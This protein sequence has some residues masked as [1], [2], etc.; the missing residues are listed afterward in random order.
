MKQVK[1]ASEVPREID[2]RAER[3]ARV[4]REVV[5]NDDGLVIAHQVLL[6]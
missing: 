3:G 2:G 6:A 5:G 4:L 1:V